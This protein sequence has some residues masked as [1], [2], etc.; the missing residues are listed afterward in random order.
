MRRTTAHRPA[1]RIRAAAAIGAVA[2][3]LGAGAGGLGAREPA[4]QAAAGGF[5]FAE[6][7]QRFGTLAAAV[8]ALN[9][10]DGTIRV[11]PGRYADCAVVTGG[12]VRFIAEEPGRAVFDGGICEGK[13]TLVLRGRAAE[14][15]GLVF[16]HTRVPD[17]NG[18]GI[19][20]ETGD[21][22]VR[23]A[24]FLDAQSGILS[25]RD[26]AATIT[27]DHSTFAGL[28]K[29]PTGTGAHAV[30]IGDYGALR[31]TASRF[32]RGTGG[33]YVKS[34]APRVEISGSSFD[35]SRGQDTN[36]MIDLSNG[37]TGRI[38]GNSF[39]VGPNKENHMT[40]I[41][42]A[43]E[44]VVHPSAGL[45]VEA[46]DARLAPA[47]HWSM[48]LVRSWTREPIVVRGNRLGT[49]IAPFADM[50]RGAGLIERVRARL[51]V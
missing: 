16:M 47:A 40:L 45:V 26:P 23:N 29:D 7:G 24:M 18:A 21:L 4:A 13:A 33:H 9:G 14:V 41:S 5:V 11:A 34:R 20:I 6:T 51:G 30:Y 32:E 43:P 3:A 25:A 19:R 17:G 44:G 1:A 27:I 31:I 48:A 49:G 15:D 38:A 37:A 35:D 10:R 50:S 36:Y 46:N 8:A 39:V 28:G 12:R 2:L 22:T 42:V